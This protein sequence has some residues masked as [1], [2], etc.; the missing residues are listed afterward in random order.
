MVP[1]PSHPIQSTQVNAIQPTNFVATGHRGLSQRTLAAAA[2]HLS[3]D[4][5]DDR[6]AYS[7]ELILTGR[8]GS[9]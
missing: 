1:Q 2:E 4:H 7:V 5:Y 3:A 8:S 9:T 6:F